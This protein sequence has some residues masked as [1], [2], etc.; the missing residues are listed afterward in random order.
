MHVYRKVREWWR[1][2]RTGP[3]SPPHWWSSSLE[4]DSPAASQALLYRVGDGFLPWAIR[5]HGWGLAVF[6][7]QQEG[8]FSH[9]SW[10]GFSVP[11]NSVQLT[12]HMVAMPPAGCQGKHVTS[13]CPLSC[14]LGSLRLGSLL[15]SQKWE[16]PERSK[17]QRCRMY[18]VWPVV[19]HTAI[20]ALP[21]GRVRSSSHP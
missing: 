21:G 3:S 6:G 10:A 17:W 16:Q 13:K 9:S 8:V 12:N 14:I 18:R 5:S 11:M 4:A 2:L 1:G 19:V 7:R 20:P 15:H